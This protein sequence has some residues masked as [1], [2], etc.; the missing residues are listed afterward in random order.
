[1]TSDGSSSGGD[2][3][4]KAAVFG[5]GFA[6]VTALAEWLP[7]GLAPKQHGVAAMGRDVVDDARGREAHRAGRQGVTGAAIRA[8]REKHAAGF[9]PAV[10]VAALSGIAAVPVG[11]RRRLGARCRVTSRVHGAPATAGSVG[12]AP[13]AGTGAEDAGAGRAGR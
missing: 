6:V 10:I 4:A 3:A 13:R 1:M 11:L 9:L 8:Q 7:V 12:T 5:G 2:G